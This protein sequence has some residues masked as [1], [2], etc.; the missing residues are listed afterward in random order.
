MNASCPEFFKSLYLFVLFMPPSSHIPSSSVNGFTCHAAI[1][2][3]THLSL[4]GITSMIFCVCQ[5]SIRFLPIMLGSSTLILLHRATFF[6]RLLVTLASVR[7]ISTLVVVVSLRLPL[8]IFVVS[9]RY[10]TVQNLRTCPTLIIK[11]IFCVIATSSA[12]FWI[13]Y[14]LLPL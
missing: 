8:S 9:T 6:S 4:R 2:S 5:K 13:A 1:K 3:K 7:H 11:C 12:K 10:G 14:C